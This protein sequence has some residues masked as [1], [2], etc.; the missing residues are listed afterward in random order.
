MP[1]KMF[2]LFVLFSP[3]AFQAAARDDCRC[4]RFAGSSKI[5]HRNL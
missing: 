3:A 4:A 2:L 5:E 1:V